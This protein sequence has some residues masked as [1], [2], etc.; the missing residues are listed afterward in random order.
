MA[1]LRDFSWWPKNWVDDN[2]SPCIPTDAV[3]KNV[4]RVDNNIIIIVEHRGAICSAKVTP[5]LSDDFLI[6]LRHIL[7]QHW[8]EPMSAV[9]NFELSFGNLLGN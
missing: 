7:L 5:Q 2:G 4:R 1:R 3:L 6:L 9:E 8:G